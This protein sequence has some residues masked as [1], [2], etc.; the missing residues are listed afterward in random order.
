MPHFTNNKRLVRCLLVTSKLFILLSTGF[1]LSLS[2]GLSRP[3]NETASE[4]KIYPPEQIHHYPSN[5]GAPTVTVDVPEHNN[6][7]HGRYVQIARYS[8]EAPLPANKDAAVWWI[9]SMGDR[10]GRWSSQIYW[11]PGGSGASGHWSTHQESGAVRQ[12]PGIKFN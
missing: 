9:S 5:G 11:V 8:A 7:E 2:N 6:F 10:P 4:S 1:C 12:Q 3:A